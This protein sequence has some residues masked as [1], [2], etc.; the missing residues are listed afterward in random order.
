MNEPIHE[1]ELNR[2]LL[3]PRFKIDSSYNIEVLLQKFKAAKLETNNKYLIKMVSH[4][5]VIDLP[6]HENHF[7][8]PQLHVELE[9]K[10]N[11]ETLIKALLGPKPKVWTFFMFLHFLIAIAFVVFFVIFYVKWSLEQ[12]YTFAM[13]MCLFTPVLSFALYFS[14]Q[15]GKKLGYKQM[16]EL[17]DY[18]LKIIQ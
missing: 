16:K 12:D 17:H 2:V 1:D 14:G 7:W 3:K 18:L 5:V 9:E 6:K 10:D 8:S 4:H 11:K 15:L 13:A